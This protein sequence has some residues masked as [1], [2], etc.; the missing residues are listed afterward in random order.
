LVLSAAEAENW[1]KNDSQQSN[2]DSEPRALAKAFGQVDANYN[3][4]DDKQNL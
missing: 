2:T 4:Y 1:Q 3:P